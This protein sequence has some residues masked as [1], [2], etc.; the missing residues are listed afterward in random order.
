MI[1]HERE[2]VQIAPSERESPNPVNE[3]RTE[4]GHRGACGDI[5]S[6]YMRHVKEELNRK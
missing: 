4:S 1:I 6:E 3:A 5:E 2:N